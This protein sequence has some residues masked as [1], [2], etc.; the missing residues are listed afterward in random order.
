LLAGA[1]LAGAIALVALRVHALTRGG[2]V[3]AFVVG[4]ITYGFGGLPLTAILLAFFLSSV[5]LG[6][7]GRARKKQLNDVGKLGARDAAQVL[8]NG[9]VATACVLLLIPLAFTRWV[10]A[11]LTAFAGAYAAATADTWG[12]E[13]GTLVRGAP[14]SIVTLRPIAAGLSGGITAAGTL[15]E[16]AGAAFI[17]LVAVVLFAR[18]GQPMNDGL[19]GFAA[20]SLGGIAGAFADSLLGA[21][22]QELR[23]CPACERMCEIDPHTCGTAAPLVRGI[24]GFSNDLVNAAATLTG[25]LVA[26]AL[27]LVWYGRG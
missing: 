16:I 2:A 1:L 25:A 17:G 12:T 4:T 6:R 3:A 9:G 18:A 15:A 22:V 5:A 11:A 21:T 27:A 24:R 10:P 19:A 23:R 14:R 7:V 8:A 26:G 13:I 20:I